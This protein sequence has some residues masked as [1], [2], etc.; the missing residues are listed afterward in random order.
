MTQQTIGSTDEYLDVDQTRAVFF[1]IDDTQVLDSQYDLTSMYGP[2]AVYALRNEIDGK[3]FQQ[4]SNAFYQVGKLDIEASGANTDGIT[5][6]T[7]NIVKT[8]SFAKAKLVQ[9]RV[10]TTTPFFVV[11]EPTII[12]IWEQTLAASGNN[13]ADTT[14]RNGYVASMGALGLDLYVSNNLMHKVVGTGAGVFSDGEIITLGGVALTMKTTLGTTAGNVL[15]GA[16]LAASLTNIAS[17]INGTAGAGTT[18]VEFVQNDRAKLAHNL[19]SAVA[20]ATTVT[21][22][23]AGYISRAETGA[24]FSFGEYQCYSP[25]GQKGCIDMVL[26]KNV[27]TD[28]QRGTSKGL[29]G[30]YIATWTRYGMKTFT[31][32]AQRMVSILFKMV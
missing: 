3:F 31:E 7:S 18:Y 15:I 17:A 28:M 19:V 27:T 12:S 20:T 25:L 24:N 10:E 2:E 14:L 11:L 1:F 16:N 30:E 5:A 29:L 23:T 21:I 32:G 8:L 9:N 26:Q 4:V 6:S 22:T 13:V